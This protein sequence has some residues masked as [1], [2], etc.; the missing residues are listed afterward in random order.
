MADE[1]ED[2]LFEEALSSIAIITFTKR[3]NSVRIMRCTNNLSLI[4]TSQ[5]PTHTVPHNSEV[6]RVYDLDIREWRSFRKSSVI[7]VQPGV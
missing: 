7:K 4:P 3:D 1:M 2:I 6:Y 5:H